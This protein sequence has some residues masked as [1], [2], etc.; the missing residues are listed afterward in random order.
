MNR[1]DILKWISFGVLGSTLAPE[2]KGD[3]VQVRNADTIPYYNTN[4]IERYKACEKFLSERPSYLYDDVCMPI[5]KLIHTSLGIG[6]SKF[7]KKNFSILRL[8]YIVYSVAAYGDWFGEVISDDDKAVVYQPLPVSS[9]Y[10]IETI[11]GKLLEFQQSKTGPDYAAISMYPIDSDMSNNS[12]H[13][14]AIRFKPEQIVHIRANMGKYLMY[15]TSSLERSKAFNTPF[16]LG[17]PRLDSD[18]IY[19]VTDGIRE[20]ASKF[21]LKV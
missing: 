17:E 12:V 8:S 7:E 14:F 4:R 21:N 18:F 11:K 20:L 9:V 5:A 10:R 6:E 2:A 15:G 19:D 16:I 13:S 1:R 3:E